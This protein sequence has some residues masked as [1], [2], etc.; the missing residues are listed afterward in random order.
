MR[1]MKSKKA[2]ILYY[3]TWAGFLFGLGTYYVTKLY[4][5]LPDASQDISDIPLGVLDLDQEYQ[6]YASYMSL[7]G[8]YASYDAILSLAG[9]GGF[10]NNECGIFNGFYLW[11]MNTQKS[12]LPSYGKNLKDHITNRLD[13]Y[14]GSYD[15]PLRNNYELLLS[16]EGNTLLVIGTALQPHTLSK[17]I[18]DN[19]SIVI[20]RKTS[21]SHEVAYR[22]KD[23]A[24]I[25]RSARELVAVC[26]NNAL[27][28]EC[29][30]QEINTFTAGNLKWGMGSVDKAQGL[31]AFTVT[32][33][34]TLPTKTEPVV[35]KLALSFR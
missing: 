33:P 34:T 29:I 12:C 28:E 17:K 30:I 1:F 2:M 27:L 10:I 4:F 35:Y 8:R 25:E 11:I 9:Q 21:F 31:A 6:A 7:S 23:Y 19:G 5:E 20:S 13:H 24:F 26:S 14:I 15:E 32:S 18:G 16:D 22:L 3:L